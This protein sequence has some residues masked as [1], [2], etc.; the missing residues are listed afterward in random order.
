MHIKE[1]FPL[2]WAE[3]NSYYAEK[4]S[5]HTSFDVEKLL[6]LP[7]AY[8]VGIWIDFFKTNGIDLDVQSLNLTLIEESMY[9]CLQVLE[10][11]IG[12]Y[13]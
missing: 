3:F 8:S 2:S 11:S 7:F 9:E 4:W 5:V 6:Q 1:K 10:H 12:H 13:S